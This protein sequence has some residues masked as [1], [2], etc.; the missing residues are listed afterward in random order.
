LNKNLRVYI[1]KHNTAIGGKSCPP[2]NSNTG[3]RKPESINMNTYTFSIMKTLNLIE[4]INSDNFSF[5]F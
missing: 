4:G 2:L 5:K 1:R 3:K